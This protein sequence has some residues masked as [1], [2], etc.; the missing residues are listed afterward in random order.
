MKI[1]YKKRHLP[2]SLPVSRQPSIPTARAR[3]WGLQADPQNLAEAHAQI[4]RPARLQ[5]ASCQKTCPMGIRNQKIVILPPFRS[6]ALHQNAN[7]LPVNNI[8]AFGQDIE[9]KSGLET[10]AFLLRQILRT[11]RFCLRR[12]SLRSYARFPSSESQKTPAGQ[13]PQPHRGEWP[14]ESREYLAR[15]SVRSGRAIT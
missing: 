4:K 2:T 13:C 1:L 9:R 5:P 6:A 7:P 14:T 12:K 11:P 15:T 3:I 10:F 8:P